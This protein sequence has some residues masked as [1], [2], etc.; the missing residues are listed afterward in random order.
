MTMGLMVVVVQ[1]NDAA[2]SGL[3]ERRLAQ[4]GA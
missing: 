2:P 4:S 1:K 3:H